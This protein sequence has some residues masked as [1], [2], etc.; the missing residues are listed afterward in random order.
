[1]GAGRTDGHGEMRRR[2]MP[3]GNRAPS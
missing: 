3:E 2:R 1:M